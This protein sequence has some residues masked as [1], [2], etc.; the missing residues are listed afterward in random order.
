MLMDGG[1][2]SGTATLTLAALFRLRAFG[3]ICD[4]IYSINVIVLGRTPFLM[5]LVYDRTG[6]YEAALVAIAACLL[7]C[8]MLT[9]ILPRY[10]RMTLARAGSRPN[11]WRAGRR[12]STGLVDEI[13]RSIPCHL[14]RF[15]YEADGRGIGSAEWIWPTANRPLWSAGERVFRWTIVA[16]DIPNDAF[17]RPSIRTA[18]I[19]TGLQM[20]CSKRIWDEA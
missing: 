7:I 8:A 15:R 5:D 9:L 10:R 19:P 16:R 3:A 12:R 6:S 18:T 14:G 11:G 13:R 1:I 17:R 20:D 2:P 4:M